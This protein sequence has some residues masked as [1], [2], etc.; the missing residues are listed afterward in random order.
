MIWQVSES[1]KVNWWNTGGNRSWVDW[2]SELK[3]K[4]LLNTYGEVPETACIR[5]SSVKL[6]G[7]RTSAA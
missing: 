2:A 6:G 4:A 1:Q 3:R 5:E 7:R